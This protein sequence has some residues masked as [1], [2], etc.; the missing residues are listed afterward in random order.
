MYAERKVLEL[1]RTNILHKCIST[2]FLPLK[3]LSDPKQ[4]GKSAQRT[5]NT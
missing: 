2:I 5:T 3:F 4:A 1:S